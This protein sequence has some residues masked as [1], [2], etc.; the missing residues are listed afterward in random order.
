MHVALYDQYGH[1]LTNKCHLRGHEI[2][3]FS[4]VFF[5]YYYMYY[6]VILSTSHHGVEQ[7]ILKEIKK[8]FYNFSCKFTTNDI[9]QRPTS[10]GYLSD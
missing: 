8:P 7:N 1:N 2:H 3:N 9:E 5:A 6:K 4:K 10:I